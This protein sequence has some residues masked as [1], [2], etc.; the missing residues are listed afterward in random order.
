MI[1]LFNSNSTFTEWKFGLAKLIRN[2]QR[3]NV[4]PSPLNLFTTWLVLLR[5]RF[6]EKKHEKMR[7]QLKFRR[8]MRDDIMQKAP[9]MRFVVEQ[10]NKKK[11][12]KKPRVIH[13]LGNIKWGFTPPTKAGAINIDQLQNKWDREHKMKQQEMDTFG[14]N[15]SL[16]EFRMLSKSIPW[17]IVVRSYYE[18][19]VSVERLKS[20]L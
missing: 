18:A 13:A 9:G 20:L 16:E 7:A 4:A 15:T 1:I 12:K 11:K 6:L 10:R 8:A 14:S 19:Q 3:T 5:K 17:A 2:M